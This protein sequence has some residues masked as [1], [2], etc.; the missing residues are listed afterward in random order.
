MHGDS[1][2]R[3]PGRS[4]VISK[5]NEIHMCIFDSD[6]TY[7]ITALWIDADLSDPILSFLYRPDYRPLFRFDEETFARLCRCLLSLSR[8]ATSLTHFADIIR[9]LALFD[10][11]KGE[12]SSD[13]QLPQILQDAIDDINQNVTSI[14]SVGDL[15]QR[16]YISQATLNRNFQKHLHISAQK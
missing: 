13:L 1:M 10:E 3:V 9:I 15:L 8:E 7:N 11:A 4:A 12:V 2:I 14:R 5:P 16:H 6:K